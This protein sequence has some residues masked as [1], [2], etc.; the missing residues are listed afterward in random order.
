MLEDFDTL[1]ATSDQERK[2]LDAQRIELTAQ[3]QKL[4]DAHY[5]GAIPLD[6]LKTEQDRIASRLGHVEHQLTAAESGFEQACSLLDD[7]LDLTRDCHAAY[8]EANEPTRRLFNQAFFDKIYID[9]DSDTR[10]RSVRVDY[11]QPFNHL[12]ARLVPARVHQQLQMSATTTAHREDPAGGS[13]ASPGLTNGV[14]EAQG[15]HTSALV[16]LRG[17]EPLTPSM[18]WRCATNCATAP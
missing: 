10:E 18:P 14:A 3:R 17:F 16:E 12:L 2:Q 1:Q 7:T 9:E 11:N 4:L 15:S 13:G 8:L 6:L 5:A